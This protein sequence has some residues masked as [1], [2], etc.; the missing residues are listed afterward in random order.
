MYS[1]ISNQNMFSGTVIKA[2][3]YHC[4]CRYDPNDNNS[5]TQ[6]LFTRTKDVHVCVFNNNNNKKN[7]IFEYFCVC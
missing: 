3:I 7:I 6:S 1:D 4:K 5:S 2:P